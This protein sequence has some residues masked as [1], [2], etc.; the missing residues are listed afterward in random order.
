MA[1]APTSPGAY[2]Y[3]DDGT[4]IE[5][6]LNGELQGDGTYQP[7]TWEF[8]T[9]PPSAPS[10]VFSLATSLITDTSVSLRWQEFADNT[11]AGHRVYVNGQ[12]RLTLGVNATSATV[13]GLTASTN[14]TL[15]VVRFN[16]YAESPADSVAVTTEASSGTTPPT[17]PSTLSW[18]NLTDT[19]VTL[20]WTETTDAT[21][22]KHRV[23]L[24][25]QPYA[26]TLDG[27]A[28]S[29]VVTG[30][31]EKTAYTA[32]VTR[33]A[34]TVESAPSP[35]ASFTTKASSSGGSSPYVTGVSNSNW[36]HGASNWPAVRIYGFNAVSDAI[37]LGATTLCLSDDDLIPKSGGQAS[38]NTLRT[39]LNSV[40]T[41]YP[42]IAVRYCNG[43]ELDRKGPGSNWTDFGNTMTLLKAVVDDLR[44]QGKNVMLGVDLTQNHVRTD[45][46]T[47]ASIK[48]ATV[49]KLDFLAFSMYP[50]G[51]QTDPIKYNDFNQFIKPCFDL[52]QDWGVGVVDCWEFGIPVD[53]NTNHTGTNETGTTVSVRILG[54][55]SLTTINV[56]SAKN[57]RPAYV[58]YAAR[59]IA[60]SCA[61]LGFPA[62][63]LCYW[64]NQ[65]TST[66][67]DNRFQSDPAGTSPTTSEAWRNWPNYATA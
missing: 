2:E 12:L 13:T 10:A 15:T 65:V 36:N 17:A 46:S 56:G 24:N 54:R 28:R 67:P 50:P 45:P 5:L 8:D 41:K 48:A 43:N 22:T 23:Y 52:A 47:E 14:Y 18:S 16:N 21:V 49:G 26:A 11:V 59:Y 61:A 31:T 66:D 42:N 64:D 4:F 57:V 19:S 20:T 32:Y 25:G 63:N 44:S 62:P 27:N 37:A 39:Q 34:G 7:V 35:V 53:T 40:F 58:A 3:Q 38:A 9:V 51:R 33:S 6:T 55:S 29:L 60:D 30:L 1:V